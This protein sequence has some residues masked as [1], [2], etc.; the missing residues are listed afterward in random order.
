[1][2]TCNNS[3]LIGSSLSSIFFMLALLIISGMILNAQSR[4]DKGVT[5]V[6]ADDKH[7]VDVF[8]NGT[9]FTSYQYPGNIEKPFLFPV[10]AFC[11]S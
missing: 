4:A 11:P 6:R 10:I 7:K 1:M 2:R 8:I 3:I 9:L 5:L